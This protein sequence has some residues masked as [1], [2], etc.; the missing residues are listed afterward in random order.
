MIGAY[1]HGNMLRGDEIG[2]GEDRKKEREGKG[3]ERSG[4]T[5]LESEREEGKQASKPG[6]TRTLCTSVPPNILVL[7]GKSAWAALPNTRI[8]L[9]SI[10]VFSSAAQAEQ[11]GPTRIFDG[12][13]Q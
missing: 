4:T 1:F 12:T 5:R 3:R 7:F 2:R 11:P 10:L 9:F 13:L 8:F 6:I